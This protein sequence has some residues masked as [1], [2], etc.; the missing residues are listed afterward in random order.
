MQAYAQTFPQLLNQ[1]RGSFPSSDLASIVAAYSLAMKLFSGAFRASGKTFLAHAIGTASITIRHGGN[2]SQ[3][4]AA[5][6]HASYTHGDFGWRRSGDPANRRIVRNAVGET[7]EGL[8]YQYSLLRWK[9]DTVIRL[10]SGTEPLPISREVLLIRLCN[11]LEEYLDL[12]LVYCGEAKKGDYESRHKAILEICRRFGHG[13]LAQELAEQHAASCAASIPD[14]LCNP[15][16]QAATA[17]LPSPSF[18][19]SWI[20]MAARLARRLAKR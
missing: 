19:R 6:L 1:A 16:K 4:S 3:A 7:I 17:F 8:V 9:D 10:A 12:G 5:I 11:E 13:E 20:A 15:T 2:I 14:E 18:R